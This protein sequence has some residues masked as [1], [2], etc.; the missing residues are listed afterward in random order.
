ML[1]RIARIAAIAAIARKGEA[2]ALLGQMEQMRGPT[3]Q[4]LKPPGKIDDDRLALGRTMVPGAQRQTIMRFDI[5]RLE[6]DV[7]VD[8][9][10]VED[11][12]FAV[13]DE[14]RNGAHRHHQAHR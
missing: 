5:Q 6:L 4:I 7:A 10:Q 1:A 12:P 2:I 8:L 14:F 3:D 9:Q 13:K 11:Q